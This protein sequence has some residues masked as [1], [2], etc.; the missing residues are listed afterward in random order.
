MQIFDCQLARDDG[1]FSIFME[2]EEK[3]VKSSEAE[4]RRR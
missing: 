4:G 1:K 3:N 2:N